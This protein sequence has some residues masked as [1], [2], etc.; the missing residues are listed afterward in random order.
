MS[1]PAIKLLSK[2]PSINSFIHFYK[3]CVSAREVTYCTVLYSVHSTL[4]VVLHTV[5]SAFLWWGRRRE[6]E[7]KVKGDSV[8][9]RIRRLLL[10]VKYYLQRCQN[11]KWSKS[12]KNNGFKSLKVP[13]R[14]CK[15]A[16][17]LYKNPLQWL[18]LDKTG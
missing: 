6:K 1:P 8:E 7:V 9:R 13:S 14:V 4:Y 16:G 15:K 5:H 3:R 2:G 18:K 12:Q 11:V 10:S 17:Q